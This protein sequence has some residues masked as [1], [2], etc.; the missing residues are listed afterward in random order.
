MSSFAPFLAPESISSSLQF[1][2][3]VAS[4]VRD[5]ARDIDLSKWCSRVVLEITGQ[6]IVDHPFDP[7]VEDKM[8]DYAK[9]IKQSL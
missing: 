4:Q 9:A 5:G 6:A 2:D 1:R 3:T 8:S 7:L